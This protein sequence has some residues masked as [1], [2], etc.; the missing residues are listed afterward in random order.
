[1]LVFQE[2]C[3]MVIYSPSNYC[4]Y[5]RFHLMTYRYRLIC[6]PDL[7]HPSQIKNPIFRQYYNIVSPVGVYLFTLLYFIFYLSKK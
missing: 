2:L 5:F 6:F 1:M 3:L 4:P 7:H